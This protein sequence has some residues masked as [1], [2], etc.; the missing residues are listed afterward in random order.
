VSVTG[1]T[2]VVGLALVALAALAWIWLWAERDVERPVVAAHLSA[3]ADCG[4]V[5]LWIHAL[6]LAVGGAG[7]LK[8]YLITVVLACAAGVL[9]DP[10]SAASEPEISVRGGYGE[11]TVGPA[12]LRKRSGFGSAEPALLGEGQ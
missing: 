1:A 5:V 3:L 9:R 6:A 2:F 4:M 7:S 11:Q 10:P 12:C 8:A